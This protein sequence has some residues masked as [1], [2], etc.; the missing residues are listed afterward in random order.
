MTKNT[1]SGH[2]LL[3]CLSLTL[4]FTSAYP[5]QITLSLKTVVKH[6]P[7]GLD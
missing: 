5:N 1:A 7:N 6:F 2:T 3:C 4:M